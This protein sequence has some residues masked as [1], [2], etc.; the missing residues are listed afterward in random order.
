[1]G[2]NFKEASRWLKQAERDLK[3]AMNSSSAHNFEWAC[4]QSQQSAEKALKAFLYLNGYRA[5]LTHSI[6]ELI[7]KAGEVEEGFAKF[8]REAKVL[9]SVYISSRYP[10]GIAGEMAPFE[11]YGEE[12]ATECINCAELI[13]QKVREFIKI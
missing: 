12:D 11:Y 5:I 13:L 6:L 1:M 4:F 3:S 8:N 10:N 7:R 2:D 9:D